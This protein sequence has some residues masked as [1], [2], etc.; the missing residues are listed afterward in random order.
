MFQLIEHAQHLPIELGVHA[1]ALFRPVELHP[2]DML[3]DLVGNGVRFG[4]FSR[5]LSC[6]HI[7]ASHG[8]CSCSV[9]MGKCPGTVSMVIQRSSVN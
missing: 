3:T 1:I 8:E 5:C 4:T 9:Q 2:R 7:L 6:A